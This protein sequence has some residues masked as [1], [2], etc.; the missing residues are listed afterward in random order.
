M[1]IEAVNN[2]ELNGTTSLGDVRLTGQDGGSLT[3]TTTVGSITGN[4]RINVGG[5]GIIASGGSLTAT[6][7]SDILLSGTLALPGGTQ[8]AGGTLTMQAPGRITL[9]GLVDL[10]G[11][12][13]GGGYLDLTAAGALTIGKL[14]LVRQQRV[15]RRRP[16]H[17]RRRL[18]HDRHDDGRGAADGENCGDGADIDVFS[19]GD[20]LLN[21]IVD[22]R[23]RGLDCSG[24]FLDIDGA[25]VFINGTLMMSGDG[26]ESDGGDLDVSATTLI[27]VASTATIDLEGGSGG[28]GDLLLQSDGDLI[29]AGTIM[30]NGRSATSPGSTL[31][32]L[33]AGAHSPYP[34]RSTP[35]A[36]P[37]SSTAAAMSP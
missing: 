34:A 24:G 8:G 11:G 2:I 26:T 37:P 19:A 22:I 9:S 17:D 14:D 18:G 13:G 1:T 33:D 25:R 23:G 4:G 10:T 30:V 12:Q 29:A 5:D 15:R 7:G 31:V 28:A 32:E 3:L 27:Q 16:G 21:G 36:A 20:V 6:A 35:A